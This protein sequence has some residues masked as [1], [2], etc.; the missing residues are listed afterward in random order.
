MLK[1]NAYDDSKNKAELD[2]E[3]TRQQD[4]LKKEQPMLLTTYKQRSGNSQ[5][6][7]GKT[8]ELPQMG[9]KKTSVSVLGTFLIMLSGIMGMFGLAKKE[10]ILSSVKIKKEQ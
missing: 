7:D 10:G 5:K 8:K 6:A 9:E 1:Q 3:V 4:S 2:L